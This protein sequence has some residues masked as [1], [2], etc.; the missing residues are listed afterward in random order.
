[1]RLHRRRCSSCSESRRA[2]NSR[3]E[4]RGGAHEP[5]VMLD[6]ESTKPTAPATEA[7]MAPMPIAPNFPIVIVA[8]SRPLPA[9][10]RNKTKIRPATLNAIASDGGTSSNAEK[11]QNLTPSRTWET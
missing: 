3:A 8:S 10:R 4:P 11:L 6:V 5:V 7:R 1:M 9:R 2:A